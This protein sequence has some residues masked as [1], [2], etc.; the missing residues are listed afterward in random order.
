MEALPVVAIVGRPNVGK[1]TLFNQLTRSRQALVADFPGLT[2]DRQYAVTQIEGVRCLVV[3]TGGLGFSDDPLQQAIEK[4]VAEALNEASVILFLVD[5]RQGCTHDD[6]AIALR[7][8]SLGKPIILTINK[9]DGLREDFVLIDFAHLGFAE[10]ARIAA[11]QRHGIITLSETIAGYLPKTPEPFAELDDKPAETE[12]FSDAL[13]EV[14]K[15]AFIGRPNVGKSTLTN[16]LLG[17]ERVIVQDSPGTTRDSIAIPLAR[18]GQKYLLID[19]AGVRRKSRVEEG[20]EKFSIIKTLQAIDQAHVLI[21]LF[22]AQEGITEQDLHLIGEGLKEGRAIILA[23]NKWDHLTEEQRQNI[24]RQIDVRLAFVPFAEKIFISA[25]HGSNVGLLW[26][27]IHRA[28]ASAGKKVSTP[29][30]NRLL[31]KAVQQHTPP[32]VNGRRIKLRYGHQGG[33]FPLRL[34]IHGNQLDELPK[35]YVRYL[36]G[37][38]RE[39]WQLVGTPIVFE[40]NNSEN[41]FA[42]RRNTLTPRQIHKKRRLLTFVKRR[43]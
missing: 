21:V 38:F 39:A 28:F 3:D 18:D 35:S 42:E 24:K 27:A 33:R 19:T 10:V 11:S 32:L 15:I 29:E 37:F 26:P 13:P 30:V 8:R 14:I 2:R 4:Q 1:S 31:Q 23:I 41:P 12:G 17:E 20:I 25:L 34:V 36:E 16:R 43:K 9:I 22:D 5:A 40:W 7:L 6:E